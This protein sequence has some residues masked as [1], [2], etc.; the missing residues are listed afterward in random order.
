[1]HIAKKFDN[2]KVYMQLTGNQ[3]QLH[4]LKVHLIY[5]QLIWCYVAQDNYAYYYVI[6]APNPGSIITYTNV[7]NW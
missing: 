7:F 5:A 3:N 2:F 1:M 6:I 4:N